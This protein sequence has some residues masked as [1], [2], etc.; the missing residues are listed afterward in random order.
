MSLLWLRWRL[1]RAALRRAFSCCARRPAA[2]SE[3]SSGS[4]EVS[5]G[6]RPV[7][8]AV[9]ELARFADGSA[10]AQDGDTAVLVTAVSRP[11]PG[12]AP[13]FLP[14]TVDYRQKAAAAGRIPTNFL[15]RELGPS[16]QEI[17][18]S[19]LIDRSL[20]AQFPAGYAADTQITCNLLAVDGERLP[21]VL[22][23]NAA[24]AALACSD[25][26]WGGPVGAVR[27][28]WAD[29]EALLNPGRR[30]LASSQ[31]NLVVTA[32]PRNTVVMLEASADNILQTDFM[33]AIKLGVKEAQN[34]VRGVQELAQKHGRPKREFTIPTVD[35]E[36]EDSVR[37][38]CET[39]LE[40]ILTDPRHDKISR[41]EAVSAVRT[42]VLEKLRADSV[43]SGG[44][45]SERHAAATDAFNRQFRALFRRLALER[46][47][48][49]DGRAP[50]E[51]RDISCR[52]GLHAP[53]HGSALFQRGQTQVMSTLTLDSAE[54]ALKS[55]LMSVIT[56]GIKPKNFMLHYEF[57]P[58][59]TNETGRP[60]GL[61]RRELGHGALAERALRAVV[62]EPFPFALRLTAEV[63]ESNG[64]SSMASV[65]AG[66]LA[67]MDAGVPTTSA[68]A[69]VAIGMVS[70]PDPESAD[71]P[72]EYRLLTDILG[73]E[74]YCGDMDFKLACT[75]SGV[76]ALQ[77]DFKLP[78]MPL[79]I[80]MEA[81]LAGRE[82]TKKILAIMG[83]TLAQPRVKGKSNWPVTEQL[84]VPPHKRS[85]LVGPGGVH[86]K[87]LLAETGV[88]VTPFD[89]ST[90]T[91]FAPSPAALEEGR[92]ELE[93]LLEDTA[94]PEFEFGAVYQAVV[95]ELRESGAVVQLHPRS[96]PVL[97]HNSQL[98]ARPVRHPSALG[99]NVGDE[100]QVKYFG[101]DPVSGHVRLSRKVLMAPA[102]GR[103]R[104]LQP[105]DV[106]KA[107]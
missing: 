74:D 14:L 6:G 52:V 59:A 97:V 32:G 95:V 31:L 106:E 86:L 25:I 36:L 73:I 103:V 3:L 56:Q 22:C 24:S 53:L 51:L 92:K 1:G 15:R 27:V 46:S 18:T 70:R 99:I 78:G 16:E 42:D 71:R 89:D 82:A 10:T 94:E 83:R 33:H 84:T 55:D 80:I 11:R 54:A 28:G 23:V 4:V 38:L 7:R 34:V 85:R 35:D 60:G 72:G 69:G 61:G 43:S 101:R 58:Y 93:R 90:Y 68:V 20:R 100:L 37:M 81:I 30:E 104:N 77:A 48:R 66:S 41:D 64:S 57:P 63:L 45:G 50:D 21:D 47:T 44:G 96:A 87:R 88:Q 2:W 107:A 102:S 29:G 19:R 26:P 75:H 67:L 79:P 98:D 40:A 9:G 5:L 49:C 12:P 17:L 8:L 13:G 62:P 76:T 65:C 91:V 105:K 39:R